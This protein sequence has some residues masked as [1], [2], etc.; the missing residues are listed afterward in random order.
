VVAADEVV[1]KKGRENVTP[2]RARGREGAARCGD[3]SGGGRGVDVKAVA[4]GD[5]TSG[6]ST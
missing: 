4:G 6:R 3:A 1:T 2:L 5:A